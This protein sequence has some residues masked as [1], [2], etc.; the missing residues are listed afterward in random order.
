MGLLDSLAPTSVSVGN[1]AGW[2]LG[3]HREESSGQARTIVEDPVIEFGRDDYEADIRASLPGGLEGGTYTFTIQGITDEDYAKIAQ[4]G[5]QHPTVV[6]LYLYWRD[7]T[8]SPGA[9]LAS[10][11]GVGGKLTGSDIPDG[12]VAVLS[13]VSVRRKVGEL[14]YEAEITARERV[15]AQLEASRLCTEGKTADDPSD[16]VTQVVDPVLGGSKYHDPT[17]HPDVP[18]PQPENPGDNAIHL[19]VRETAVEQL[20]RIAKALEERSGRYGRGML[21]IR[22]GDLHVGV[23]PIPLEGDA[24]PLTVAGGLIET[25]VTG[26]LTADPTRDPCQ[27]GFPQTRRQFQL[28]L[29]GRPDLFPGD[30]VQINLPDEDAGSTSG[31]AFAAISDLA[32][33][34]VLPSMPGTLTDPKTTV[35]VSGVEHKLGRGSGFVTT[36]SGVELQDGVD[37][38]DPREYPHGFPHERRTD[39]HPNAETDASR[40]LRDKI[41]HAATLRSSI[42]VGEVRVT[43]NSGSSEPPSQTATVWQ[44]LETSDGNAAQSRRLAISR[45]TPLPLR[46]VPYATPW[47]WGK[48]GLV[49]PRYPGTRVVLAHRH[50]RTDDAVDIGAVWESGHGPDSDPGDWWLILPVGVSDDQSLDDSAVPEE[51]NGNAVNDLTDKDGNRVIELGELT[52]RVGAG[53]LNPAGSRPA[54][55]GDEGSVTIEH[56]DGGASIVIK[57]D[58]TITIHAAK[59]LELKSDKDITLDAS[60]V[61]VKVSGSMDVS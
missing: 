18:P 15:F 56:A 16:A 11:A 52:V 41:E 21:L 44:G 25:Q 39:S 19:Q 47:A 34:P 14:R 40:V 50:G 35:Y 26:L 2:L 17:P 12:P 43:N 27:G 8:S 54:R 31:G 61:K 53:S 49:L 10:I 24:R 45:P 22:K 5:D 1:D 20:N 55:A 6:K 57:K 48:C 30:T 38:W 36:L 7:T 9:Y 28:V 3:F 29:K 46:G 23:R 33:G 42:D 60:N 58:G 4:T 32:V 59:N 37:P 51:P 13:I